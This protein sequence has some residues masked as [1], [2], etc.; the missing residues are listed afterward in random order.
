MFTE[1]EMIQRTTSYLMLLARLV[2][3]WLLLSFVAGCFSQR[4]SPPEL[5]SPKKLGEPEQHSLQQEISK[6]QQSLTALQA[7]YAMSL[8]HPLEKQQFKQVLVFEQKDL[9]EYFRIETFVTEFEKLLNL[10]IVN[11]TELLV[12]DPQQKKASYQEYSPL[13]LMQLLEMPFLPVEYSR[14]LLGLVP[15]EIPE[16]A[17]WFYD[18]TTKLYQV[19]FQDEKLAAD[20]ERD[21]LLIFSQEQQVLKLKYVQI[22]TPFE[23]FSAVF[24]L[25]EERLENNSNVPVQKI[26]FVL[27]E[28]NLFG[29][30][31]MLSLTKNPDLSSRRSRLFEI[32]KFKSLDLY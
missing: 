15:C 16:Q 14:L 2:I 30:L 21:I 4:L 32:D 25:K 29:E 23:E 8:T 12:F 24:Q 7:H 13:K 27:I 3:S 10:L 5:L 26:Q 6:A 11:E 19:S 18:S 1:Q 31:E 17:L 20:W 28:K 22:K 9:I